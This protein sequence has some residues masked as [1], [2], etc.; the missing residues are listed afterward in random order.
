MLIYIVGFMGAGKTTFGQKLAK[1]IGYNFIDLDH[2]IEEQHLATINNLFNKLG[3]TGFRELERNALKTT[4]QFTHTVIATGGGTPCF[5]DNMQWM[6]TQ[7]KVIYLKVEEDVLLS[8][9]LN[10]QAHRPL[11]SG[12]NKAE[13]LDFITTNLML[14]ESYYSQSS[15]TLTTREVEIVDL[16]TILLKM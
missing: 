3:E 16:S 15:I 14:R 11:I 1:A 6:L 7:G 9:L 4:R 10:E 8:R 12:L 2:F 5:F 13:L